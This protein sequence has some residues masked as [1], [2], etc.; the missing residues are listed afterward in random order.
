MGSGRYN[1][2]TSR[3][4]LEKEIKKNTSVSNPEARELAQRIETIQQ[5]KSSPYPSSEE[6]EHYHIIDPSLTAQMKEMVKAEQVNQ[7]EYNRDELNKSYV[8]KKRGQWF[9][10][11]ILCI[12]IGAGIYISMTLSVWPGT[13]LSMS[14]AAGIIAQYLKG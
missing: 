1:R 4:K 11:A 7:H 3:N 8:L 10:F 14:G 6:Y 12:I 2:D 9:G 13:L 5:I